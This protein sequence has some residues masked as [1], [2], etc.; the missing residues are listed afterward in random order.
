MALSPVGA[1][2]L[3]QLM[4][5]TAEETARKSKIAFAPDRLTSDP[6]YN[7]TLGTAHLGELVDYWG[8][9]YVL[10]IA[11]YNAGAGNVKKWIAANGD[12]REK[13]ADP[14]RWI[15]K[16]PVS[17]TRF[18]VQRVME[19]LEIYRARLDG[20]TTSLMMEDLKRG[21]LE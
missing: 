19:N 8:G 9:S 1:R 11:S 12:P 7:V 5:P 15:E 6:A 18:Y 16:I 14:V 3:M 20:Q 10:A 13:G 21:S 4:V 17:E 2:G